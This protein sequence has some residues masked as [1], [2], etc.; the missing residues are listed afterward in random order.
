MKKNSMILLQGE[1]PKPMLFTIKFHLILFPRTCA[2]FN[3]R[4]GLGCFGV[5]NT[6]ISFIDDGSRETRKVLHHLQ[7]ARESG[8]KDGTICTLTISSQW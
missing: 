7:V 3:V 2:I 1:K 4:L 8:I 6:T 5:N